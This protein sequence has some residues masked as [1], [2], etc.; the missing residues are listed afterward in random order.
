[1]DPI[2]NFSVDMSEMLM[3][4]IALLLSVVITM[5]IKDWVQAFVK[6]MQFRINKAFNESD[7]VIL[8]GAPAH[9]VKIGCTETVFG[10][11]S[12]KGYT[13]RY[14]PNSRIPYLKLEKIVDSEL[15]L[16]TIAEKAEKLQKLID[17]GQDRRIKDNSQAINDLKNGG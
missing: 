13:W 7:H 15:H 5:W 4:W 2:N 16:D 8:D 1:M 14:V 12:D 10:V 3:P 6:G 11:Y 9:I 17:A